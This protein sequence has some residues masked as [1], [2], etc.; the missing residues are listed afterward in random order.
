[1]LIA[2]E[3]DQPNAQKNQTLKNL[4]V[5]FLENKISGTSALRIN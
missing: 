3:M 2:L 5:N 4:E 1:V